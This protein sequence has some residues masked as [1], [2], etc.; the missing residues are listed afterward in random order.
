MFAERS[1]CICEVSE[2]CT[3]FV[4]NKGLNNTIRAVRK[5]FCNGDRKS[6]CARYVVFRELGIDKVPDE[7]LPFDHLSAD[8]LIE[9]EKR[10]SA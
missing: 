8:L 2:E 4:R 6:N 1:D 10:M 3:F 9:K 7:L 5:I